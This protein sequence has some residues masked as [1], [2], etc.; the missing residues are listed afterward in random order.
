[1]VQKCIAKMFLMSRDVHCKRIEEKYD[2]DLN[3]LIEKSIFQENT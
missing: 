1:M 3:I 2:I